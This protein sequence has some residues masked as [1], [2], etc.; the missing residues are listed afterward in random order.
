MDDKV[1][2]VPVKVKDIFEIRDLRC[3]SSQMRQGLISRT[4]ENIK[5]LSELKKKGHKIGKLKY[6]SE[7]QS[8]PFERGGDLRPGSCCRVRGGRRA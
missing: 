4:Q 1:H 7:V 6:K 8:I 3:L 5:G 2:E